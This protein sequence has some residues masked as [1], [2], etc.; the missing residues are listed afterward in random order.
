MPNIASVL[1]EEIS[2]VARKELRAE[3]QGIKKATSVHRSEI[4]SLKRRILSLEQTLRRLGRPEA[5][6]AAPTPAADDDASQSLRFSPNGLASQRKRLGLSAEDCGLLVDVS[7]KSIYRW[8]AGT[9]RPQARHLAAVAELRKL[10]K[11]EA[12][13]RL[14]A[15][16]QTR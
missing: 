3:T 6:N 4:A 11:K 8:E 5:K 1:K 9:A 12:A 13:K 16:Q 7:G 10:G 15:L 2:R 14:S